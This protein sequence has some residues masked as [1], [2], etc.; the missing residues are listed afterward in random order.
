MKLNANSEEMEK[1]KQTRTAI[2]IM[3]PA[4]VVVEVLVVVR[5]TKV[6]KKLMSPGRTKVRKLG[7]HQS[8][9]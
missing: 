7:G 4:V 2:L 8:N 1:T 9:N 3:S 6:M 5:K